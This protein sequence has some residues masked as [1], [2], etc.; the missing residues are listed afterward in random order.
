MLVKFRSNADDIQRTG[1]KLTANILKAC[2]RNYTELEGR[3]T[4][5]ALETCETYITVPQNY[6]IALF[7]TRF[8]IYPMDYRYQCNEGN[9]P[10]KVYDGGNLIKTICA[11]TTPTPIFSITN[12]MT[13]KFNK[14]E[15]LDLGGSI[16]DITYVASDKGRGC[17]GQLFN[18]G[19][20]FSSPMY[21]ENVRDITDCK[22]D[23]TVPQNL[24]VAL[25][26]EG[27]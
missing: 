23:V 22:W 20:Q 17:G 19:G 14:I 11:Q 2:H 21:P 18:F 16:Y 26:F 1:F 24:V 10:L 4:S 5:K 27:K 25:Q 9:S 12:S 6:T 7:F 8:T 15:Y 3:I 13:L